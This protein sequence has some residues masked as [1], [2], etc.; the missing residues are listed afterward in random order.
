MRKPG[1][2][3]FLSMAG[4]IAQLR[5][6]QEAIGEEIRLL[7][8]SQR[9]SGPPVRGAHPCTGIGRRPVQR[10][11]RRAARSPLKSGASRLTANE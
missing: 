10:T 6:V 5:S 1:S 8:G 11:T 7:E 2:D 4:V 3:E 9:E